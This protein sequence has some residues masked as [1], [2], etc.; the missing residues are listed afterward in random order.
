MFFAHGPISYILNETIQKKK[1]DTLSNQE[2]FLV[3]I[4]SILFGIFPDIDLAILSMTDIPPFTH[5]QVFTHSVIYFI[6]LWLLLIFILKILQKIIT[7]KREEILSNKLISV[8]H[9]SFLVGTLSH[10]FADILFSQSRVLFPLESQ[11]TILGEVLKTNYFSTYLLSPTFAVE[12]IALS[13]FLLFIFKKYSKDILVL[14]RVIYILISVS[15]SF[16]LLCVYMNLNTYNMES[17]FQNGIKIYDL[18]YDGVLDRYDLDTNGNGIY[19]MYEA[20]KEQIASFVEKISSNRYMTSTQDTFIE[21]IKYNYGAFNSYRLISQAYVQQNLPLEPILK[22]YVKIKYNVQKYIVD[23]SYPNTLYE[24]LSDIGMFTNT[25]IGEYR[26]SIFFVIENNEVLNMGVVIS[27][28]SFGTVL[29]NDKKLLI[30]K[31]NELN[32]V[33]PQAEIKVVSTP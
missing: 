19:N 20:D 25:D 32:E 13:I 8:I 9:I 17:Q 18:D 6:G 29:P 15:V 21:D 33:Y 2:Q 16:F 14:K 28:N 7:K 24:Y 31:L 10:L 5:H 1:I 3:L 23:I 27:E 22:E 30:H 12:L 4:L 11:V 26:G